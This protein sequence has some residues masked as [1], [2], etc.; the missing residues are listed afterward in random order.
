VIVKR[1]NRIKA[2]MLCEDK[3]LQW[4]TITFQ[5]GVGLHSAYPDHPF[6]LTFSIFVGNLPPLNPDP[7]PDSESG[8]GY[9]STDLIE[10]GSNPE[11][12]PGSETL[13]FG[14]QKPCYSSGPSI[15][16]PIHDSSESLDPLWI[17]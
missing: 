9:G 2:S 8:P 6:M 1:P 7:D 15:W 14:H 12:D 4:I 13:V 16:I 5:V 17:Q 3:S 11:M 10:S